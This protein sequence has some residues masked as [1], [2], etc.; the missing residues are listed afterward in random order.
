MRIPSGIRHHLSV[1]GPGLLFLAAGTKTQASGGYLLIELG[2]RHPGGLVHDVMEVGT[3][4]SQLSAD[5]VRLR[6]E[7]Q[8]ED[9]LAG[10]VGHD[11]RVRVLVVAQWPR[12][13]SPEVE[14]RTRYRSL[15]LLV[16]G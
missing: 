7:L 9:R 8:D 12:A 11:Q 15:Q 14:R 1:S 5:L 3:A 2:G 10:E 16:P 4:R 6:G 13:V